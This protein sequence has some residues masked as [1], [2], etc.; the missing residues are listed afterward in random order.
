MLVSRT[1]DGVL[2]LGSLALGVLVAS[3]MPA[4]TAASSTAAAH[5]Q[6]QTYTEHQP[7][8]ILR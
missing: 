5:H 6:D 2:G 4:A 3:T 7:E 1:A 8:P